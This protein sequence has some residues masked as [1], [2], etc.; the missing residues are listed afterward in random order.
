MTPAGPHFD[1]PR[2]AFIRCLDLAERWL[3][4]C[5]ATVCVPLVESFAN[6]S[7]ERLADMCILRWGLD[8]PQGEENDLTWF[9][10]HE[11]SRG[12]LVSAFATF[13]AFTIQEQLGR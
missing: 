6:F 12:L 13:R 10:A 9:E 2:M 1:A 11:A 7:D 8:Q 5:S 3:T 4:T